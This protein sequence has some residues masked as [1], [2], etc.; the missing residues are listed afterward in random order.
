[1]PGEQINE[2]SAL[3]LLALTNIKP[4]D[5]WANASNPLLGITQMMDFFKNYYKKVYAPNTRERVRRF[6][7]HQFCQA[8][9]VVQNP[10]KPRPVNSPNN[11]YQIEQNALKLIKAF[12]S[13]NWETNLAKYIEIVPS[14]KQKYSQERN[15]H[16]I[17]LKINAD[18]SISLSFGGQNVLIK[19]IIEEFGPRFIPDGLAVYIGDTEDKWLYF[20]KELYQDLGMLLPDSHG[21]MPDVIIY[22][23]KRNWLI[24]IEAVTS[25]GPINPKRK[26]ELHKM[27]NL[28]TAGLV[29]VTTF[30]N[31]KDMNKYLNDISW[32]TEVW[33]ADHPDHMV[34]FN[35]ERFLGPY[36]S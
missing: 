2:R 6:T 30:L 10:D 22:D 23:N 13:I 20:D 9:L 4:N 16:K 3:T 17:P 8:G 14:L 33:I 26:I 7:I 21:K 18:T 28:S 5:E 12:A 27:F 32:E 11:V 15:L 19:K 31:H 36:P 35:G 24:L 34:H 1:M 29:Y 25:H